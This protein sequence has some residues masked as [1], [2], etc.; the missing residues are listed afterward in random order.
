MEFMQSINFE[1]LK[2]ENKELALL[3]AF[4]ESYV[5][6]DPAS[7]LVKLR[8]FGED[9]VADLIVKQQIPRYYQATFVEMLNILSE[10][11]IVPPVVLDKLHFLRKAGNQAAHGQS[12]KVNRATAMI[13]LEMA[14][15]LGKWFCMVV[16]SHHGVK[17]LSFVEPELPVGGGDLLRL[18]SETLQKMALQEVQLQQLL[19]QLKEDRC[20]KT[21]VSELDNVS[22]ASIRTQG[23]EAADVLQ[24]SEAQ[25]RK[26]LIDQLLVQAGWDVGEGGN[27]ADSVKQEFEIGHQP[28]QSGKGRIDYV[29][30]DKENDKPVAIIEAKKTALDPAKGRKQA[31]DYATALEK[32]YGQYPLVFCTNGYDIM[33]HDLEKG[34]IGRR[35]YGFYNLLSVRYCLWQTQNRDMLTEQNPNPKIIDRNYQILAVKSVCEEFQRG[36]RKALLVQATGTGKTRV[37]IALADLMIRC[38]WVKRVLFLCDRREL[39]KQAYNAFGEFIEAE[40]RIYVTAKTANDRSKRIYFATYPAMM[41]CFQRFDVG[42]FDLVIADES[43]RSIYNRYRDLFLYFDAYQV[44]LTATP[45][46]VITHNTYSLFECE[47]QDPTAYFSYD[48]AINHVPPYLSRYRNFNHTTQ[49]L[50]S[51]IKYKEMTDAQR[52]QLEDQVEDAELVDYSKEAIDKSVFNKDTDRRI[53]RNL[54]EN[55]IRDVTGQRVGKTIVFARNHKHALLLMNLFEEMYPQYMRP[56]E[57]FCA[58]IDHYIDRAEQLIDDF[59]GDGNNDNLTIAISVDMLDTGIDVPA[60]VNLVF[61]KPVKSYVKFWQMI[62]RGTRLCE[63][64]FG[65]GKDKKEFLIFDHWGNFDYFGEN[66]NDCEP[67]VKKAITQLLFE[68][69][70]DVAETALKNQDLDAFE[71]MT[72]LILGDINALPEDTISVREKWRQVKTAQQ[73]E[74]VKKFDAATVGLLR[75][76]IAGLMQW[77]DIGGYEDAYQ[78]D[79]L[80]SRLQKHLL[81]GSSE[82]ADLK[83]SLVSQ[84]RELPI[85]IVQVKAKITWIEK[86]KSE[87]FWKAPSVA[88]LEDLREALRGVMKYRNKTG[89][90]LPPP[91]V[92]DVEDSM[93]VRDALAQ[94]TTG[95][96]LVA[97]RKRVEGVLAEIFAQSPALRKIKRGA[98]VTSEEIADLAQLVADQDP[99]ININDLLSRFPNK[100]SR[101]DLALRQIIGL[102]AEAVNTHFAAFVQE[103]P[104][105]NSH[106]IRFLEMIKKHITIYG[107]LELEQLYDAPFTTIHVNG[108]S[109]IFPKEEQADALMDLIERINEFEL[110]A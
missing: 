57:H 14:F 58:V 49:F 84:V 93:E 53:I 21:A 74:L 46:D 86:A 76:E 39:R 6:S 28:T 59:K 16:Y 67:S 51:G 105:L 35:T 42:F 60:V 19:E 36:K 2:T 47:D 13:A 18:Q 102:D 80:V 31:E 100:A 107:K 54:M 73:E 33:L 88:G 82:F 62:G 65:P 110:I 5:H 24:F 3:G 30:W 101:L 50:R 63:N 87:A 37:A 8:A 38:K 61:A 85:N 66:T 11:N 83:D 78:L 45:R 98:A 29:L 90:A 32:E 40:P 15:D 77:R 109:G 68:A 71:I 106:Q 70:L 81:V 41:K 22:V 4:A 44:G 89:V 43:H 104:G 1:F 103:T 20:I 52:A 12:G 92:I 108:I 17:D 75:M 10:H 96:D 69:R 34:H 94:Y 26:L 7:S 97:Y 99:Q 91:L 56:K 48:D 25:T 55:G 95:N 23:N 79:L 72:K 9:L 64:L 27:N